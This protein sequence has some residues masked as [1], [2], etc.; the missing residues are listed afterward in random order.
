LITK[1]ANFLNWLISG[2]GI[3][4]IRRRERN[5]DAVLTDLFKKIPNPTFVI[6]VGAHNGSSISRFK[7]L[8]D[9]SS[10]IHSFE[11]NPKLVEQ[12]IAQFGNDKKIEIYQ[13]AV[14]N[15]DKQPVTFNIHSTSSGSSSLLNVNQNRRFASRRGVSDATISPISVQSITLDSHVNSSDFDH[16]NF[17]K[18]DTQGTEL[19]VLMGAKNLLSRSAIDVIEFELI[20]TDAY[21]SVNGTFEALSFLDS[22]GYRLLALSNDGRFCHRG[23][24]DIIKNPE[25]QFDLIFVSSRIFEEISPKS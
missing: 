17:L 13:N 10:Q 12:L 9:H 6:D 2:I 7:N 3:E 22:Y 20:V 25:L 14:S 19:K 18:I 23:H 8:F 16:V 21:E 24:L 11:A 15:I 5:F 1:L 4:V